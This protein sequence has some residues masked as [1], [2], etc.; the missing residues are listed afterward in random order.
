MRRE[1]GAALATVVMLV[2]FVSLAVILLLKVATSQYQQSRAQEREDV[3]VAGAEAI[4]DR[5]AAKLTIDSRYYLHWVDEAERARVCETVGAPTYGD[6][7]QPGHAWDER[8]DTWSYQDPDP[9]GDGVTDWFVHPVLDA[10]GTNNDIGVLLEVTPPLSGPVGVLVVGKRGSSIQRRAITASIHATPLSEFYRVTQGDLSYGAY[11]ETFGKIYSGADVDFGGS[12]TAH[13]DVYAEGR[14][15]SAP[16]VW[17]DGAQGYQGAP[18]STYGDIRDVYPQPLNFSDFW[19]DLDLIYQSACESGGICLDDADAR[20]WRVQAYV[21]GGVGKLR[22]WKSTSSH[23]ETWW[24][25][26][27]DSA[28]WT[29]WGTVDVPRNGTLWANAHLIVGDQ[30]SPV[31]VDV[32]EDGDSLIDFVLKGSLTMYAGSSSAPR[33]VI[34]TADTFYDDPDSL[35]ILALIAS[36]EIVI[37]PGAVGLDKELTINAAMLGQSNAWRFA[38]DAPRDSTLN[39]Y[40]SIATPNVGDIAGHIKYRNYGF[41][42]RLEYIRPPMYPLL[43][44]DWS[45][46]DWREVKLPD[47][48]RL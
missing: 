41:D 39:T 46:D 48:A 11:A 17:A 25:T 26:N 12:T 6:V 45:Y 38:G 9:N 7:V 5:Y 33:N 20:A 16:T 2:M 31:G 8:C 18:S 43:D 15:T 13:A 22:I 23:N 14:I 42:P 29:V 34:I 24:W 28:S 47:W 19:D 35:D 40:G 27:A 21:S 3:V 37:D 32:P 44:T 1:R 4:L 30:S 36:D 10:T